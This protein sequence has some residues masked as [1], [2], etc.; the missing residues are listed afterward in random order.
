VHVQCD[1]WPRRLLGL[2]Q[3]VCRGVEQHV[4]RML[5]SAC[6]VVRGRL[7]WREAPA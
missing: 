6:V 3:H 1:V 5:V 4:Q 2:D 7:G